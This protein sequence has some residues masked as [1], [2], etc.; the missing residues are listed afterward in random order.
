[1]Y[2]PNKTC[3]LRLTSENMAFLLLSFRVVLNFA[4]CCGCLHV[5]C[6]CAEWDAEHTERHLGTVDGVNPRLEH[7]RLPADIDRHQ[8]TEYRDRYCKV[9]SLNLLVLF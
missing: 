2:K 6:A 4:V 3:E 1:M 5:G 9:N 7:H 8:L